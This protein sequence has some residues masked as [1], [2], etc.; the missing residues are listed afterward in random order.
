MTGKNVRKKVR[1]E[2]TGATDTMTGKKA[3][4][5]V[6]KAKAKEQVKQDSSGAKDVMTGSPAKK[7]KSAAQRKAVHASKADK[8]SPA[9]KYGK[10]PAKAHCFKK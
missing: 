2:S 8:K 10:S 6:R 3:D 9:K 1:Q 7:Y 5:K 4:R